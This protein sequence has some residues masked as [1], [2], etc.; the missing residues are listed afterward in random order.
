M[1]LKKIIFSGAAL[2]FVSAVFSQQTSPLRFKVSGKIDK[3]SEPAKMILHYK[4]GVESVKD[5]IQLID[6]SFN[7]AGEIQKPVKATLSVLKESDNPRMMMSMGIDGK[8]NGRDA[9]LLYLDKGNIKVN[10]KT[11]QT[12]KIS[13]SQAHKEYMALQKKF[14]PVYDKLQEIKDRM[15]QVEDKKSPEFEALSLELR[16][17]FQDLRPIEEAFIRANPKSWVSWNIM[18]DKAMIADPTLYRELYK[19]FG[20]KFTDTDDGERLKNNIESAYATQIGQPA[21]LFTQ[22][23]PEGKPV[24]LASLKGQYVLVDFWA[25]WCGPCRVEN[26]FVV[27]AYEQYKDKNFEILGVSLDHDKEAWLKAIDDDQLPWLHVSDLKGWQNEVAV[28]YYIGAVPQNFLLDPNGVI[29]ARNLRGE[30]LSK[31]LAEVLK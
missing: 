9:I 21:P 23:N 3:L 28:Q 11:L 10:G 24:S 29:I 18:A 16:E 6:G 7:F 2:I 4:N 14:Q 26:P 30:A 8:L 27:K 22:N 5:T 19:L 17:G 31:K 15:D 12:A 13:G 1:I 25:S 20:P